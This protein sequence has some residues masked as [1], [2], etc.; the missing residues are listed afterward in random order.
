M[1]NQSGKLSAYRVS[2]VLVCFVATL[3]FLQG[4]SGTQETAILQPLSHFPSQLGP[5]TLNATRSSSVDVI[6]LLGV[7]DYIDYHYAD[8]DGNRVNLYVGFYESV[9]TDGGYHSPKNCLPGGGWGIESTKTIQLSLTRLPGPS[10]TIAEMVIRNGN[11]HQVV[12]YWFQNRG[13]IIASEYWEKV[14]LVLDALFKKRR[15]GSFVRLMAY[16][17]DGDIT[18]AEEILLGFAKLTLPELSQY[19][20]GK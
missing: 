14:Y 10:V 13:R 12:L 1:I 15:D 2:I 6:N 4:V 3:V 18:K 7:D 11:E 8:G 17:P 20:P 5:W 9:G 16:A 19:L